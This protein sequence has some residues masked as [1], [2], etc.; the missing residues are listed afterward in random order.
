MFSSNELKPRRA[1]VFGSFFKKNKSSNVFFFFFFFFLHENQCRLLSVFLF[2]R[3]ESKALK[4]Y[5][6]S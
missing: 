5:K 4:F 2:S 6:P 1:N 3:E